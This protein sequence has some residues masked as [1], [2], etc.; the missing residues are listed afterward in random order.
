MATCTWRLAEGS[1]NS[2]WVRAGFPLP[3]S[4]Q[5]S[6]P[7]K[8]VGR[9]MSESWEHRALCQLRHLP[10]FQ[11]DQEWVTGRNAFRE[12]AVVCFLLLISPWPT[13]SSR[14]YRLNECTHLV[15]GGE[16]R[17]FITARSRQVKYRS[18]SGPELPGHSVLQLTRGPSGLSVLV[19]A[20]S[21][22]TVYRAT[23]G[24]YFIVDWLPFP[25]C[26]QVSSQG[27]PL[28]SVFSNNNQFSNSVQ[29]A[30][31]IIHF[32]SVLT[33]STWSQHRPRR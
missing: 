17:S 6:L 3:E 18:D 30:C 26:M 5:D 20:A 9:T 13:S 25:L 11:H 15:H 12:W 24:K 27:L 21:R 31:P 8:P 10:E 23:E 4:L 28:M 22:T 33:L 32:I 29:T 16:S 1:W 19:M 14:V 2:L 7:R